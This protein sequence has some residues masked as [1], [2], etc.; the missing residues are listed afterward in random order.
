MA[1]HGA[2]GTPS[3]DQSIYGRVEE[4]NTSRAGDLRSTT[5][6]SARSPG[7]RPTRS[8]LLAL[9]LRAAYGHVLR[10]GGAER[11]TGWCDASQS[12]SRDRL[13]RLLS[14]KLVYR[15]SH[16]EFA[17]E[18]TRATGCLED[19]IGQAGAGLPGGGF[20]LDGELVVG[21]GGCAIDLGFV[22]LVASSRSVTIADG[23]PGANHSR[24]HLSG[25]LGQSLSSFRG[26][27][28]FL[29]LRVLPAPAA[30]FFGYSVLV[31]ARGA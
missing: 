8:R 14:P 4:Y 25:T 6:G 19:I 13:S 26:P 23:L 12:R 31:D 20:S 5:G 16:E 27:R 10:V 29:G 2:T 15:Q 7:S 11:S 3:G 18:T 24:A 22:R 28:Q 21:A 1:R 17:D 30:V 9:S